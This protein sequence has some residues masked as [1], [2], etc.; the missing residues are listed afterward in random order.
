MLA[1]LL[2]YTNHE[3]FVYAYRGLMTVVVEMGLVQMLEAQEI[4]RILNSELE[5]NT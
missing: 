5:L 3:S 1:N 4:L 2:G